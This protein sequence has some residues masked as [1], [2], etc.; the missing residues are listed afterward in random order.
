MPQIRI[1]LLLSQSISVPTYMNTY[2]ILLRGVM[3]TGRNKV[4]MAPLRTALAGAGLSDVRTYIQSGN[5]IAASALH[6]AELEHLV[7]AVIAT[8]FGGDIAVMAR[9][10]AEFRRVLE[11]N[12]FTDA[13]TSRLYFTLLGSLPEAARRAEFASTD[14]SPENVRVTDDAIYTLYATRYSDSKLNNSTIER[15]LR[16]KATTRN[17]NTTSRLV[18]LSSAGE[19]DR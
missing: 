8:E 1:I 14:W 6:H 19:Q 3:P 7:H 4:P 16:V 2:V 15:R 17:F 12:P 9:T 5:V 10:A 11:R 13:D 18:E